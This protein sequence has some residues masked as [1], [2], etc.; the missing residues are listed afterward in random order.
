MVT[1]PSTQAGTLQTVTDHPADWRVV[2]SHGRHGLALPLGSTANAM[3]HRAP[4][5]ILAVRI[6][7]NQ[8]PQ[9]GGITDHG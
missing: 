5:D 9:G 2:G 7:S 8:Q 3:M 4:C 6:H 1:A